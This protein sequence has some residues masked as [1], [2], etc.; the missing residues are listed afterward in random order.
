MRTFL[1]GSVF[2]NTKTTSKLEIRYYVLLISK[3][4]NQRQ[5]YWLTNEHRSCGEYF[6]FHC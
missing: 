3:T 2:K 6:A 5:R 4:L 1:I